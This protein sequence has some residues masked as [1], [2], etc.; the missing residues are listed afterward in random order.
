MA[1]RQTLRRTV[2][3]RGRGL[4]TGCES[5]VR[6]TPAPARQG[7]VFRRMDLPDQPA[8]PAHASRV[9]GTERR[10]SLGEGT[11][12]VDTVEHLLAAVAAHR[13]DDLLI[14]LDGP[15]LP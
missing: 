3:V 15:E 6:L 2:S 5:T 1:G 11:A 14:E 4:H 13:I 10:T 12:T 8:I 7:I 9:T